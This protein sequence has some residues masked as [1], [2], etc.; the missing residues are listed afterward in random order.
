[1]TFTEGQNL[2]KQD[3][4]LFSIPRVWKRGLRGQIPFLILVGPIYFTLRYLMGHKFLH[5]KE[6]RQQYTELINSGRGF[7]VCSPHWTYADPFLLVVVLSPFWK[8][9]SEYRRVPWN[10]AQMKYVTHPFYFLIY[11]FLKCLPVSR[12]A[13]PEAR[14]ATYEF[15]QFLLKNGQV[16][17]I[18]PEGRR[19]EGTEIDTGRPAFGIDRIAG[20]TP[21]VDL[22]C[23]YLRGNHQVK[24]SSFPAFGSTYD[25]RW[26]VSTAA[27]LQQSNPET[28][29]VAIGALKKLSAIENSRPLGLRDAKDGVLDKL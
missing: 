9:F 19:S 3:S 18:F 25:L 23:I 26:D 8:L 2:K 10:L 20:P 16:L 27:Q 14:A 28:K 24:K 6:C 5:L 17:I 13:D 21:E 15:G 29:S 12:G 7:L 22:M 4:S 11:Y 1:M